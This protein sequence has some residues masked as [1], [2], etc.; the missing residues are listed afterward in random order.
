MTSQQSERPS[1]S[2]EGYEPPPGTPVPEPRRVGSTALAL[3]P[4]LAA[5]AVTAW[6]FRPIL[7]GR[8]FGNIGDARWTISLHEHWYRVWQGLDPIRDLQSYYPLR[9]TLGTSDAFLFQGQVYGVARLL[10]W[11]YIPS[12][13]IACGVTFLLGAFGVAALSRRLLRF[14]AAQVAFVVLTC[15]SYPMLADTIHVQLM[16]TLSCAWV[17]VGLYDLAV[18]RRLRRAILLV[19]VLPPVLALSSWYAALLL[20]TVLIILGVTLLVLL[21]GRVVRDRSA[22]FLRTAGRALW[23]PAGAVA[24]VLGALGYAGVLWVYVPSLNLLPPSTWFELTVNSPQWSD[25]LNAA[26]AGGGLWSGLYAD[27]YPATGWN[28]EQARGYTPILFVA[29]LLAG[30]Y[31]V[32]RL[33]AGRS[34]A[35]TPGRVGTAGLLAVWV[36]MLATSLLFVIDARELSLFRLVW[37]YV[38]G[39]ESLRAPFRVQALTYAMGLFLLLRLAELGWYGRRSEHGS[40]VEPVGARRSAG[41]DAI[42]GSPDSERPSAAAPAAPAE[43]AEPAA[44]RRRHW[45]LLVVAVLLAGAVFVEMQRPPIAD[46]TPN[47]LLSG[48]FRDRIPEAQRDCDAV[49]LVGPR[50]ADPS[51]W[52]NS[53]D[54]TM[55]AMLSGVPTPQGYSRGNPGGLPGLDNGAGIGA[56]DAW[57]RGQGFT[58]RLCVVTPEKVEVLNP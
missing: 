32:R 2:P 42:T 50:A 34:P 49:I 22:R 47:E 53:I 45:T 17:L 40:L 13:V 21:E 5:V 18:G 39:F 8:L 57:M 10:G 28:A 35:T 20:A 31:L 55:F 54:A 1:S 26:D 14:A 3:A 46:W 36:A 52:L 24:V 19:G 30:A 41:A 25:L 11:G 37:A 9:G 48:D 33:L 43:P 15:A 23:S 29:L 51:D 4:F 6:L 58:G 44:Q 12:W 7:D 27:L 56:I 38:P 16:G